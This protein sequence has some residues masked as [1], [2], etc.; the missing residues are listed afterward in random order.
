MK[1][2]LWIMMLALVLTACAEV[3]PFVDSRREA[4][5]VK[6]V[7][8]STP[9]RIA[10]CYNPLWDSDEAV[11]GPAEQICAKRGLH[12]VRQD[13]KYFNCRLAS[14]NTAFFTCKK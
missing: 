5:Q 9:D 13:T 7:G 6:L 8:Q 10:V 4:G 3:Q 1:Q 12:A 14:P 11:R 2:I